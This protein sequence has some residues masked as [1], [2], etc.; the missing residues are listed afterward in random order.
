M[1][2][3]KLIVIRGVPHLYNLATDLHEDHNLAAEH[4][5]IVQQLIDIIHREHRPSPLFPV[6]LPTPYI[7]P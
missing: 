6:T 1:G 4:P 7:L 2:D 5:D 3:W